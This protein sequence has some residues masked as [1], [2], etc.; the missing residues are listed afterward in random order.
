MKDLSILA[1]AVLAA[2]IL[3]SVGS[4][5]AAVLC[6]AAVSGSGFTEDQAISA[7]RKVVKGRYGAQFDDYAKARSKLWS[8]WQIPPMPMQ[9]VTAR[10]CN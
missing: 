4:A 1:A 5:D 9:I 2:A 7:W 8:E 10:P 3:S 6:K